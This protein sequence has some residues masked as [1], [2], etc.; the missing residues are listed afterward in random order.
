MKFL[1]KKQGERVVAAI[2][3]AENQTSAEIKVHIA[4][5]CSGDPMDRAKELFMQ[6]GLEKT[7]QRNG[8]LIYVAS[9]DRKS[10]ILGDMGIDQKV[11]Q[12]YWQETLNEMVE[13][14][15]K[16]K[17]AEGLCYAIESIG[18][19]LKEHFPYQSDDVNELSD[20]ISY[21]DDNADENNN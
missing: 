14:F 10:A 15:K 16:G 18:S 13:M 5:N 20:D 1:S 3:V 4:K 6:L 12:D 21:E 11:G 9:E 7:A 17:N 2:R 8:I 19:Q